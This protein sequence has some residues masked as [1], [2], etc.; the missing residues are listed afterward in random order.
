MR[1]YKSKSECPSELETLIDAVNKLPP[2][3][4]LK[5]L[6]IKL[7]FGNP[8]VAET[9]QACLK[10]TPEVFQQH[11]EDSVRGRLNPLGGRLISQEHFNHERAKEYREFRVFYNSMVYYVKRLARERKAMDLTAQRLQKGRKTKVVLGYSHF[12]HLNWET[13]PLVLTTVIKRDSDGKQHITGLAALI[14]KFDDSRLR[15]CKICHRIF[16]A[17]KTNA[18]TCGLKKCADVLGNKKRSKK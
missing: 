11:I 17:K 15:M 2:L 4:R 3:F 5:P 8:A 16:W 6:N 7:E 12:D 18:A 10:D 13:S 9:L 1:N 14:G